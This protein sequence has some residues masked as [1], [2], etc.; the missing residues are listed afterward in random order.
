VSG[1]GIQLG[2]WLSSEE[3][4]PRDL[5]RMAAEAEQAG[6][7]EAM[8]SDHF[9]P[10]TPTQGQAGFVWAT[11]GAVAEA[12][13]TLRI[14]TGVTAPIIRM[15]PAV[16]AH[17]AST[18]ASMMPGRFCLGLGSGER[19]NEQITGQ[20]WPRDG[21]RRK[22]LSEA[23]DVI[24]ALFDGSEVNHTGRFFQVEH[25]QLFT[26][27]DAPP[28]I[29]VAA[30]GRKTTKLAGEKAD[31]LIATQPDPSVV[32]Q[33]EHA[34][35]V[36]KPK[37]AQV[38]VCWAASEDDAVETAMRWWPNSA[39]PGS[40]KSELARP[41]DFAALAELV[42]PN[43]LRKKVVCGPDPDAHLTAIARYAAAGFTTVHIHQVGPDQQGFLRFYE[44][45][46]LPSLPAAA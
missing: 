24:R 6:F 46:I 1:D 16:V 37:V 13:S 33:F 40:A 44:R 32:E 19:L 25:A 34:G 3:H 38:H 39:L 17:A 28:P 29:Y 18:V 20:R 9:H 4:P 2:C 35:G 42:T 10:W 8:I 21:E 31:G 36:G 22:M 27:P 30:S 7:G 45:E 12:T 41:S 43:A 14:A 11:L 26:R 15:H 5:V 23:I